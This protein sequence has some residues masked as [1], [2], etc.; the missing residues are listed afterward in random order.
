LFDFINFT[1]DKLQIFMLVILRGS[2]L[3]AFAPILGNNS[4]PSLIRVGLLIML[5]GLI[6]STM[7]AVTF[8]AITS[9]WQLAGLAVKEILVGAVISLFFVLIFHAVHTAGSLIGYQVGLALANEFDPSI[10][11]QVS[12]IGRFWYV[13]AVLIFLTINGH[14]MIISAFVDSYQVIPP[15]GVAIQG[16]VGEL[17]IRYTAYV[18]VIGLKIAAPVMI[19]LFLTDVALGTIA[20]TMPTMNVFFV[21]FPIKI[22][23]CLLVMALALPIFAYVLE[24]GVSFLDH[25]L[26]MMFLSMGKA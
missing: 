6:V 21:G 16:G 18:F 7:P 2:G 24:R 10:G 3:F 13:L 4:I 19:T 22:A 14:H 26:N 12:V 11:S 20:K 17:I 5:S 1:A 9:L 8:P 25:E 23:M 15:A